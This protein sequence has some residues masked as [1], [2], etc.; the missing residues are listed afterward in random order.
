MIETWTGAPDGVGVAPGNASKTSAMI[1]GELTDVVPGRSVTPAG[2]PET[3]RT[4]LPLN[5]PKD[6][7]V[8]NVVAPPPRAIPKSDGDAERVKPTG[9][10]TTS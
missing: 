4:T 10:F 5:P 2:S 7:S 1:D 6:F 9:L 8:T 3:D